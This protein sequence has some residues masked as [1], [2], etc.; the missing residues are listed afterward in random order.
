MVG[1]S[2]GGRD[3]VVAASSALIATPHA[4][5]F[6]LTHLV[7]ALVGPR[8][9]AD[10]P[11]SSVIQAR[12]THSCPTWAGRSKDAPPRTGGWRLR[13]RTLEGRQ[14]SWRPSKTPRSCAESL[15]STHCGHAPPS[16]SDDIR[17]PVYR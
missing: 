12:V 16:V 1:P 10:I 15:L 4:P 8:P 6:T 5:K 2:P 9:K 17:R 13:L 7:V 14:C 3:W 11:R